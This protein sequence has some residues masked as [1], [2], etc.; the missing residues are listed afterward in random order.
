M[1]TQT[2]PTHTLHRFLTRDGREYPMQ[3]LTSLS[4]EDARA[5][6]RLWV[7]ERT[8]FQPTTQLRAVITQTRVLEVIG[9]EQIAVDGA[10]AAAFARV[11]EEA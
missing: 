2:P 8:G 4:L 3:V 9:P 7:T 6:A 1:D 10:V 5:F 11:A